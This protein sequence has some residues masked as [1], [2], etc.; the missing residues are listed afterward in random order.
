MLQCSKK[1]MLSHKA[2]KVI[3]NLTGKDALLDSQVRFLLGVNGGKGHTRYLRQII[4][5]TALSYELSLIV[6]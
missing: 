2:N 3:K 4:G 6:A 1:N 5:T